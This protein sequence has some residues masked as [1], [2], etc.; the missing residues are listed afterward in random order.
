MKTKSIKIN[1]IL[2]ALKQVSTVLFPLITIPYISRVI[3]NEN[4]GK[5]NFGTSI[6]SYFILIAAL[7]I[8]AYAIREGSKF[9]IQ[10]ERFQ[11][12]ANE[13]FTINIITTFF[14]YLLLAF[15]LIFWDKIDNYRLIIIIQ[16]IPILFNTLGIEWT[17][18]IYEDFFYTTVRY[19]V[20]QT[21]SIIG[22]FIFVRD[23]NDI[24][25]YVLITSFASVSG[26][27]VNIYYIGKN[28]V[29]VK[30]VK[31]ENVRKHLVPMIY[32]FGNMLAN[33]IYV[34]SDITI[35]TLLKGDAITGIYSIATKVYLIVKQFINSMVGV[36]LPRLSS[37]LGEG[38]VK[39]YN[40]LLNKT[41]H[42]ILVLVLPSTVGLFVLSEDI[43]YIISGPEYLSGY[44]ALRIL[45]IG[46]SFGVLSFFYV[47][48]IMIPNGLEKTTLY[49]SLFSAAVNIVLNFIFIPRMGMNGAAIT[50]TISEG[51]VL[52]L[53]RR[54]SKELFHLNISFKQML[55]CLISCL[56]IGII[57]ILAQIIISNSIIVIVTAITLSATFYM[58]IMVT[59]KDEVIESTVKNVVNRLL[60]I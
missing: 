52:V 27:I 29:K 2:S 33:T 36:T 54:R 57:S 59:M 1:G 32:L 7:G 4:Y 40:T 44:I 26:N 46:L 15:L 50:T 31:I 3:G 25:I 12:F 13:V 16:A 53:S 48:S 6:V 28:Y 20:I 23:E 60:K 5:V 10:K 11:Q 8:N 9:R 39:E 30:L 43:I 18:N 58:I 56:G 45:A 35:L 24:L 41:L 37:Y 47:Y 49:Y 22:M 34:N 38:N 42:T 21:L 55:P 51:I 17:N 19:L 14:S